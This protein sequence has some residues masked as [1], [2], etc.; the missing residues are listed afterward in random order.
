MNKPVV[1][2][3]WGTSRD[4]HWEGYIILR[5]DKGRIQRLEAMRGTMAFPRVEG[6]LALTEEVTAEPSGRLHKCI[7]HEF[8]ALTKQELMGYGIPES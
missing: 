8:H 5:K 6:R 7:S 4:A 1:L 2:D 3:V